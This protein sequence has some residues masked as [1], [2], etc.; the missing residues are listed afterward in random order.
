M[1]CVHT[2]YEV[3]IFNSLICAFK[4][5]RIFKY[6]LKSLAFTLSLILLISVIYE[7][8]HCW[9]CYQYKGFLHHVSMII[10]I[11]LNFIIAFIFFTFMSTK[12]FNIIF[13]IIALIYIAAIMYFFKNILFKRE[14]SFFI[15]SI[16]I[17]LW[18]YIFILETFITE[19]KI[20][21]GDD[22][23]E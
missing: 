18:F 20:L 22:E 21:K 6:M 1:K 2:P 11:I 17:F 5:K 13:S 16:I 8:F 15:N 9:N 10:A 23:N 14:Y 4:N 19:K 12:K 3:T 7:T